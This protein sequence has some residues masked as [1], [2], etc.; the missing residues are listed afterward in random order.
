MKKKLTDYMPEKKEVQMQGVTVKL[1]R[2]FAEQVHEELKKRNQG[3]GDLVMAA[4]MK[5]LDENKVVV[6]S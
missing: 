5:F 3:W 1:P 2:Q 6:K 4:C